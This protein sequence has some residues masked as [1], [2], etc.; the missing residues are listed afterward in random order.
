MRSEEWTHC[1]SFIQHIYIY[2][3]AQEQ[4]MSTHLNLLTARKKIRKRHARHTGHFNIVVYRHELVQESAT[5]HSHTAH[6]SQKCITR[7]SRKAKYLHTRT[8]LF[9]FISLPFSLPFTRA[10]HTRQ[11][12]IHMLANIFTHTAVE[13]MRLSYS[14]QQG[15]GGSVQ[16]PFAGP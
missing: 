7:C 15:G 13:G 14:K 11:G 16:S 5:I 9:S 12:T 6:K 3:R 4:G 2:T 10:H 8:G 1:D